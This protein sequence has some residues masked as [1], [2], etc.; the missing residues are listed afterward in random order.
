MESH[1]F[2]SWERVRPESRWPGR[3]VSHSFSPVSPSTHATSPPCEQAKTK[4]RT[5]AAHPGSQPSTLA[6]FKYSKL[7]SQ[8]SFVE[9]LPSQR[10]RVEQQQVAN[11]IYILPH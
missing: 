3:F 6:G 7:G 11:N 5:S 8:Q 9:I 10:D 1:T 2:K 4:Q